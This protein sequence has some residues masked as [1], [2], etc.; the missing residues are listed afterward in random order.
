M[1]KTRKKHVN[2]RIR[3]VENFV[4]FPFLNEDEKQ[5]SARDVKDVK[6]FV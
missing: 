5:K 2:G 1:G 6:G 3:E 4:L